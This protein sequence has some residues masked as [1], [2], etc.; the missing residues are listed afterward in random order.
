MGSGYIQ[1]LT[2]GNSVNIFNYNP[3]ISFFKIYYRRHTNFF[4]NNMTIEGD[5]IYNNNNQ[6]S[7]LV[8][9][10]NTSELTKNI[11]E[12][13]IPKNG[14][15]LGK[16]YLELN[17]DEFYFEIFGFNNNL[18]ST[19]NKDVLSLY[20]SYYIKT[21]NFNIN[22]IKYISII[23]L[24]FYKNEKIYSINPYFTLVS[25][26]INDNNELLNII[27]SIQFISLEV[28]LL[29]I[30]YNID[31]NFNFFSFDVLKELSIKDNTIFK[32]I[33]S[34]INYKSLKYIQIDFKNSLIS[35]N[36]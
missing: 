11:L 12:F 18:T 2:A 17:F 3:N 4:I 29:R 14:D 1:L 22:D 21:N 31:L 25:S 13:T 16:S 19:L 33:T 35:S 23:K 6:N 27:K 24:N 30:F 15:L 7:I 5:N 26:V 32:Y 36:Q 34:N 20:D 28:N 9:S 8:N 10:K